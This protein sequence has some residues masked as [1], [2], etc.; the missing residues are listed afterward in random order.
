MPEGQGWKANLNPKSLEVV[1]AMLEP[2]LRGSP[3]TST[4]QFERHGYF[5]VDK[6]TNGERLVFNRSVPLKDS[7]AKLEQ[8]AIK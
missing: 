3:V 4:Y 1:Q 5:C 7:W 2:S 6:D 8:K